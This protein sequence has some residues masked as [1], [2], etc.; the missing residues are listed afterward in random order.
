[1]AESA[2]P[3]G[4]ANAPARVSAAVTAVAL[5][6]VELHPVLDAMTAPPLFTTVSCV[7]ATAPVIPRSDRLGPAARTR[8]CL[9]A[10]PPTTHPATIEL[11]PEPTDPR[12]ERFFRTPPPNGPP[13]TLP[14]K[15]VPPAGPETAPEKSDVT[16]LIVPVIVLPSTVGMEKAPVE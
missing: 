11:A 16:G 13:Q 14:P 1:M 5:V 8:S 6:V 12:V 3:R 15:E 2:L 4:N 10:V 7:P 9:L